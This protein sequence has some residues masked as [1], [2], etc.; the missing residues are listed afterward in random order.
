MLYRKDFVKYNQVVLMGPLWPIG[1]IMK[2]HFNTKTIV[3]TG[4]LL[5]MEIIFQLIGNYL[6][7]GTANINITLVPIV[8]AGIV[9]GPISAAI[10]GF[11]N[12][13][14]ALLSPSTIAFFM[15]VSPTGTVVVCLLKC[16]LAGVI[17]SLVY[18]W[19]K[20]RIS[21][22]GATPIAAALVPIINTGLF[23]LGC[24][25][26]FKDMLFADGRDILGAFGFVIVGMIGWNFVIELPTTIVLSVA[27]NEI[28][29]KREQI[30]R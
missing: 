6:Q 25:I 9:G 5:A 20:S 17:S 21:A 7:I 29:L 23:A 14:M 27:T 26:F 1:G 13:I 10:L 30:S 24:F 28:L 4:L 2:Q 8:I 3:I 19:L 16:T 12:G 22:H 18:H 15:P 11:F